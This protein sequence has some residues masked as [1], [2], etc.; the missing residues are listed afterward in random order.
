MPKAIAQ[1]RALFL[2]MSIKNSI[3]ECT[4]KTQSKVGSIWLVAC[5]VVMCAQV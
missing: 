1:W 4:W 2:K 3:S 5:L